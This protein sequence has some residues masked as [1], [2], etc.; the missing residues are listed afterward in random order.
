MMISYDMEYEKE[1]GL[2]YPIIHEKD[3]LARLSYIWYMYIHACV[4][5]DEVSFM[6]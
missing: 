2:S 3:I 6:T 4:K 5:C 1:Y